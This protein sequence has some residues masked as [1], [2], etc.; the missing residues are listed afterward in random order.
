MYIVSYGV[1]LRTFSYCFVAQW[2]AQF[3]Q[4]TIFSIHFTAAAHIYYLQFL[5]EI[6]QVLHVMYSLHKTKQACKTVLP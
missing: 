4:K 2:C 6:F 1:W 5:N 3:M